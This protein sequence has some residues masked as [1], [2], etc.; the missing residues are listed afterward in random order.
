MK[1]LLLSS[2]IISTLSI[3]ANDISF[4]KDVLPIL[5]DK[6]Y[7]CHGPD[8]HDIKGKL[9]LHTFEHATTER[10]YT[11]KSGKKKIL[12]PAIIPGKPEES[13]V[14][15]RISTDDEDDIMPPLKHH[16]PLNKK[17]KEIIRQWI[18]KGAEYEPHWAYTNIKNPASNI[19]QLVEEKLKQHQLNFNSEAD[20]RTLIRRL[21]FDLRGLPASPQEVQVFLQDKSPDAWQK[22]IDKFLA[23]PSYGEKMAIMWLDLVRYADTVG[24]HGDQIQHVEAYR[25]YVIKAFNDNKAFDQ[26][27][28]E[29]LAGDLLPNPSQEQLVASAYNRLNMMSREGGA[30]ELEYLAKYAQDRVATTSITW[31]GSTLACAECHDHKYDPFT[32]KDFYSFAAFFSDIQQVGVYNR[33]PSAPGGLSNNDPFPPYITLNQAEIDTVLRPVKRRITESKAIIKKHLEETQFNPPDTQKLDELFTI[34]ASTQIDAAKITIPVKFEKATAQVAFEFPKSDKPLPKLKALRISKDGKA[35]TFKNADASKSERGFNPRFLIQNNPRGWKADHKQMQVLVMTPHHPLEGDIQIDLEFEKAPGINLK[36]SSY[37]GCFYDAKKLQAIRSGKTED[38]KKTFVHFTNAE[39]RT[40]YDKVLQLEKRLNVTENEMRKICQITVPVNPRPIRI[41]AKGNWQDNSGEIVTPAIPAFLG[42]IN[43]E[44][45]AT[46]LD[47]A[48]WLTSKDNPLTSRTLANRLWKQFFGRGLAADVTDLGAQGQAPENPLLLDQLASELK[49]NWDI[50]SLIKTIVSSRA[51]RQSSNIKDELKKQDPFNDLLARQ[52]SRRLEAELLR[53]NLLEISSLLVHSQGGDA[54]KPY[55]PE[56]YYKDLNFPR[57]T[58]Q[59]DKNDQQYRRG[60]Y[61]HR[62]RTYLHPMLKAFDAPSREQCVASRSVSNTPLQALNL[63]NDPSFVEAAKSF[64]QNTVNLFKNE[65]M[66]LNW[67]F[68]KSTGRNPDALELSQLKNIIEEEIKYY[69]DKPKEAS[70]LLGAGLK[71]SDV[72]IDQKEL[73]AWT[74]FARIMLNLHETI[75][76]Y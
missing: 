20:K 26:F 60:V 37:T 2:L 61:M 19:D 65:N 68:E 73:A 66:R 21:S 33:N 31:M 55:Q 3:H 70:E 32:A 12:E 63:L 24:Y 76:V 34:H 7:A 54:A 22:L 5:S 75:T 43:K 35:I 25:D 13:I 56:G 72:K 74:S 47:L 41:L 15:E 51:Y 62:Q 59:A 44:G 49:E 38:K 11:S 30:Q 40:H 52:N 64:A 39:Y 48:E 28:K 42:E 1:K 53:D 17:Q 69:S 16:K 50:K 36:I 18:A 9:Q 14:W 29:Q 27:T 57:R 4:N 45:P 23:S 67:M 8:A 71:V 58:Y 6:C 46:R 10:H